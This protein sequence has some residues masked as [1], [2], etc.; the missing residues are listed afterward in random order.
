MKTIHF[1]YFIAL[2]LLLFSVTSVSAQTDSLISQTQDTEKQLYLIVKINQ[3]EYIGY[4]LQ[5]DG[6]EVLIETEKLGKIYIPKSDIRLIE[7]IKDERSVVRGD[8]FADGPFT[9]RYAFTTN[10]F[11][12]KKGTNY[13]RLNLYGPEAH[14]GLSDKFSMGIMSS[15]FVSPFV[16]SA[17]YSFDSKK[18]NQAFSVGTLMGNSGYLN[19]MKTWGGLHYGT[20][21]LGTPKKN[22]SISA[23]VAYLFPGFTTDQPEPGIYYTSEDYYASYR[24][25]DVEPLVGGIVSVA[26]IVKVGPKASFVFDSMFGLIS[27]KT[28]SYSESSTGISMRYV[29][30]YDS[31]KFFG[32]ALMPGMRFQTKENS[33]FQITL[34][35]ISI[36]SKVFEGDLPNGTITFP[37]PSC[38]WFFRF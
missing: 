27:T 11:P 25:K 16:L 7:P 37:M 31:E 36:K 9:T 24:E 14:F 34:T 32:M 2:L 12:L 29:V 22:L 13:G 5:D 21:T 15:W 3:V 18:P 33:A 30:K 1:Q 8:Y 10:A 19:N 35:T 23:G 28:T 38:S 6:R 20:Y 17:K 26:G 4:I